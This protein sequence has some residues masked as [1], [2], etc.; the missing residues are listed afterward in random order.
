MSTWYVTHFGRTRCHFRV[1]P[2]NDLQITKNERLIY[3][4]IRAIFLPILDCVMTMLS[5]F[6]LFVFRLYKS[7]FRCRATASH[8]GFFSRYPVAKQVEQAGI[9]YQRMRYPG[10][11]DCTPEYG[12]LRVLRTP[13]LRRT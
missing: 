7:E 11:D 12:I 4:G 3:V 1:D 6:V 8:S 10:T 9:S 5:G 13:V 2:I